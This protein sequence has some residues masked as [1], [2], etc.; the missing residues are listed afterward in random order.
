MHMRDMSRDEI[1]HPVLKM[2][3]FDLGQNGYQINMLKK[4]FP[5]INENVLD[6]ILRA[7]ECNLEQ[8]I[9]HI[10]KTMTFG[11]NLIRFLPVKFQPQHL[12][13][14]DKKPIIQ[15]QSDK[16]ENTLRRSMPT[17]KSTTKGSIELKEREIGTLSF[18]IKHSTLPMPTSR[19]ECIP[20][21]RRSRTSFTQEAVDTAD[22]SKP[23][24]CNIRNSA[25]ANSITSSS[26]KAKLS[27][28]ID[29]I[30]SK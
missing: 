27:F 20:N 19:L 5:S 2:N 23:N 6:L 21:S 16:S 25:T 29:S 24:T 30:L 3:M 1:K 22:K 9:E 18:K 14:Q 12:S 11:T 15:M 4:I 7:N 28:S 13:I 17:I 26:S 8:T 10:V